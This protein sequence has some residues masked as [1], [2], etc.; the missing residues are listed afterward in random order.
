[1]NRH[2]KHAWKVTAYRAKPGAP[3][4]FVNTHSDYFE[5]LP[6]GIEIEKLRI[7]FQIEKTLDKEPNTCELVITNLAAGTRVDLCKKPL[8]VRV[9]AGYEE[10]GG[11]RHL[12]AG[13]LR[14]GW[15]KQ[16]GTEWLTT[17]QLADGSRAFQHAR[18]SR[19]YKAGTSVLTAVRDAARTM[20]VLLPRNLETSAELGR[21][22]AA[23]VQLH[24]NTRDELTRLLAPFGYS[25]SI[26]SGR[27]VILK[28]DEV[29]T[30][31]A[32]VIS[33]DTGMLGSPEFGAP[34]KDGKPPTLTIRTLLYP[35]VT[36]GGMLSVQSESINGIF[37]A[38]RVVH[39]G[40]SHGDDWYTEIEAKPSDATPK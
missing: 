6:N 12:F 31:R 26:Q 3:S 17:L 37:R 15:S 20:G 29:D 14:Y 5:N 25:W 32:I 39:S 9:D 1:M 23:G 2:Y 7:Q 34:E 18:V 35:Q 27:L 33:K 21:A 4:G 38:E 30:T 22:F 13:D 28:D 16:D 40:D 10:D 8:I 19:S 36:P 24:G 11:A